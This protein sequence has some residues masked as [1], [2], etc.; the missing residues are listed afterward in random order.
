MTPKATPHEDFIMAIVLKEYLKTKHAGI[1]VHK[2]DNT[3]FLL[4]CTINK[5]RIRRLFTAHSALVLKID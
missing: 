2:T 3:K 1:K 5:K 4:E